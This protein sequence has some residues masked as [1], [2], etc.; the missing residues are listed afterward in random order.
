MSK[1][2]VNESCLEKV[3]NFWIPICTR[4]MIIFDQSYFFGI[5]VSFYNNI[6]KKGG[7]IERNISCLCQWW[8]SKHSNIKSCFLLLFSYVRVVVLVRCCWVFI[9][10][11]TM[12]CGKIKQ[13][14]VDV[15]KNH[16][17]NISNFLYFFTSCNNFLKCNIREISLNIINIKVLSLSQKGVRNVTYNP[18]RYD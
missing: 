2:C 18:F 6:S 13:R 17:L 5:T 7:Q 1:L 4:E 8:I 3:H 14:A 15:Q 10:E 11:D 12:A 9:T 16:F